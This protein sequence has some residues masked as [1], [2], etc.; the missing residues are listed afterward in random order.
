MLHKQVFT[1]KPLILL[2]PELFFEKDGPG[3]VSIESIASF[4][5]RVSSSG[6]FSFIFVA[7]RHVPLMTSTPEKY[8]RMLTEYKVPLSGCHIINPLHP[9]HWQNLNH[10][11]RIADFGYAPHLFSGTLIRF[12]SKTDN[13]TEPAGVMEIL[14]EAAVLPYPFDY[15]LYSTLLAKRNGLTF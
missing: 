2:G 7:R 8:Y 9:K 10:L 13:S 5:T 3:Q 15:Q 1:P 4:V 14:M 12:K 6:R 11:L